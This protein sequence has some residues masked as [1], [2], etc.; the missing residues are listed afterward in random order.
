MK[1]GYGSKMDMFQVDIKNGKIRTVEELWQAAHRNDPQLQFEEFLRE[2]NLSLSKGAFG[3]EEPVIR[4]FSQ[5]AKSWRYG[6]RV[7]IT[8]LSIIVALVLSEFLKAGFP[9]V[10]LRWV[11]G[12]F[13][14]LIAP[15]FTF[16][17]TLFPSRKELRGL[18]RF[19]LTVAMSL[20]LVPA[21]ALLLNY[22]PIGIHEEP[23]ALLMAG[24]SVLFLCVGV[25][26][27]F[28]I[29]QR[30]LAKI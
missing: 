1:K 18:N 3:L 30:G 4:T 9:L 25:R 7:W 24:L 19:A 14:I 6:F 13:L 29:A 27:E 8:V 17:W 16:T 21:I 22:T 26:R 23:I 10:A 11:A 2:L 5:Y 28:S 12:S 15:G 20:F